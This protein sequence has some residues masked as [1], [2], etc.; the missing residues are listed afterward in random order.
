MLY[1]TARDTIYQVILFKTFSKGTNSTNMTERFSS[2]TLISRNKAYHY[3]L[4][5][6]LHKAP[7]AQ[8]SVQ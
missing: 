3:L 8:T 4:H 5:Y 2:V 6:L 1:Y 7:M